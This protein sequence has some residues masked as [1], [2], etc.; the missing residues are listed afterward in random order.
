MEEPK[1]GMQ[2]ELVAPVWVPRA[3]VNVPLMPQ[4]HLHL[5]RAATLRKQGMDKVPPP[6]PGGLRPP[7]IRK[8]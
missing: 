3:P 2:E 5:P 8:Y 7:V 4:I 6:S 1:L